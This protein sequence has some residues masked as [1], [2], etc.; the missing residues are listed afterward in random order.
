MFVRKDSNI[1]SVREIKGMRLALVDRS[2][3]AGYLLPLAYFKK[4]G[5]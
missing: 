4:S 1:R 3:M 5:C 2:T